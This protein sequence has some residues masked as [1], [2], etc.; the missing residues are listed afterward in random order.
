MHI[1]ISTSSAIFRWKPAA[2]LRV[3]GEDAA[4]FLQGQFTNDLRPL[5]QPGLPRFMGCG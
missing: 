2:W 3:T 4:G 5:G 1:N